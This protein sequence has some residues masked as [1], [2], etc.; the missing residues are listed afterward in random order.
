MTKYIA[1]D[2]IHKCRG[3]IDENYSDLKGLLNSNNFECFKFIDMINQSTL[4]PFD[5]LVFACPDFAKITSQ[6][7]SEIEAWVKN[8]GGGLLL[9]SHAGGDKGRSSNL[10]ELGELFGIAFE[11]DQVL[12]ERSNLGLENLP[13]IYNTNFNPPHAIT[14]DI[15]SLCYRAGCSLSVRGGGAFAIATSND[16]SDPFQTPLILISEIGNGRVC[17]I[18][19]YELFRNKV[20]GGIAYKEHPNLVLNLFNWLASEA[21]SEIRIRQGVQPP[22]T[23]HR[24]QVGNSQSTPLKGYPQRGID[25]DT[26]NINYD[27]RISTKSE[28]IGLLKLFSDQIHTIQ[29]TIDSLIEKVSIEDDNIFQ[30]TSYNQNDPNYQY[31]QG[32]YQNQH[33]Q[34]EYYQQYSGYDHFPSSYDRGDDDQSF[35]DYA[36]QTQGNHTLS[37]LPEKP[38]SL[39]ETEKK[40]SGLKAPKFKTSSKLTDKIESSDVDIELLK[41]EK[42]SLGG[43][44]NSVKQ[45]ITF[46]EK[47]HK[48]GKIDDKSHDKQIKKLEKDLSTAKNRIDAIDKI[49]SKK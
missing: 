49:L 6:E 42:E 43:K 11:N 31:Q 33:E 39:I 7:I 21:R 44:V 29:K 41:A 17:A 32:T 12:D 19:S 9:L 16:T 5:I 15:D 45:L 14:N 47:K 46:T 4:K 24:T 1:F 18:G 34:Q 13:I 30:D 38:S 27:I 2:G 25:I 10:N 22:S 3:N 23:Q 26:A 48:S 40:S 35:I 37:S 28:L 8:D 20:G 36:Y